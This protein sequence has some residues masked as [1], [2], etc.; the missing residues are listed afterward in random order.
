LDRGSL[1]L[2]AFFLR[3]LRR[4]LFAIP[5]ASNAGIECTIDQLA[6]YLRVSMTSGA[7]RVR[8]ANA[9]TFGVTENERGV[10]RLTD[11][12]RRVADA[13]AIF[14]SGQWVRKQASTAQRGYILAQR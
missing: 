3:C 5:T 4:A 11:I 6:A 9:A 10:I 13:T 12:G 7:F 8:T 1:A 14:K 2:V